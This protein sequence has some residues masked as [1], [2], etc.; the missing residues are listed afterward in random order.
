V[1][2][3]DKYCSRFNKEVGNISVTPTLHYSG[4]GTNGIAFDGTTYTKNAEYS[5]IKL[6]IGDD[7]KNGETYKLS[8]TLTVTGGTLKNIGG[9]NWSFL[10]NFSVK[11]YGTTKNSY[12]TFN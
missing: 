3:L 7:Y 9:H 5:G 4:S 11:G 10:T 2:L 1:S 6:T 8:Y 12:Y